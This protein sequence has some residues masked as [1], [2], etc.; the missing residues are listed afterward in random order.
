M[1][2]KITVC[3]FL[4]L[5]VLTIIL[6]VIQ[7][8]KISRE[9]AA[10]EFVYRFGALGTIFW[11]GFVGLYES[12]LFH[13]VYYYLFM[14]KTKTKTVLNFS[15]NIILIA[16]LILFLLSNTGM[17]SRDHGYLPALL[18]V[19]YL[20]VRIAYFIVYAKRLQRKAD[21]KV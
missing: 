1:K 14:S 7:A 3:A 2:K 16:A 9:E 18:M 15:A 20:I 4:I 13:A 21:D 6:T 5:I 12:D 10:Q 17:G 11:G 19:A 8:V